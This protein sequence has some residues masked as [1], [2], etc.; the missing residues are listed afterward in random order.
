MPVVDENLETIVTSYQSISFSIAVTRVFQ[1]PGARSCHTPSPWCVP[2]CCIENC[3]GQGVVTWKH[4]TTKQTKLLRKKRI[5][6]N[7][8]K[9]WMSD[10]CLT[11]IVSGP[12]E[13]F[14]SGS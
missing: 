13:H 4:R 12:N 8:L 2:C 14:F 5:K 10:V 11:G 3:I 6:F 1:L 9:L 7:H